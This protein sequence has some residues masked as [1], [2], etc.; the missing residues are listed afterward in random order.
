MNN[1][2]VQ[3]FWYDLPES[4]I[5]QYPLEERDA[6][7]LL[8]FRNGRIAHHNFRSLPELLPS[9]AS[10]FFNNTRV[11]PARLKFAKKSGA[12]IEIFLLH[13]VQPTRLVAQ[14]MLTKRSAQWECIIGNKKRWK[15]TELISTREGLVIEAR[16]VDPAQNVVEFVWTPPELTFSEMLSRLGETPLPPY[17]NREAATSDQE[18]Y[19]TVYSKEA[20]AVAAPTA[21]LHFT[22]RV[23][24]D[25]T[26]KGIKKDFLTLH[27]SAGTFQPIK[28]EN[29]FDHIM[30]SEQV[31]VNAANIS[32][33]LESKMTVAVG[34][35]AMR[36]LESLYWYGVKLLQQ[37]DAPFE[38]S[39]TDAWQL[40]QHVSIAAA[41]EAIA[42][43][44]HKKGIT[45]LQ[46][47]TS[48]YITPG[49]QFRICKGLITNFH[50]PGSTLMLLI[51][52]FIGE[53][54]KTVYQEA[55]ANNYRFLSYGDS[56]LLFGE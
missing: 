36:T 20:G 32:N 28:T 18:K 41:L 10:L 4:R 50:Q 45:S 26:T 7:N 46:G 48:I 11:I 25:L 8:V 38:I 16:L 54:W 19:Q 55:L 56:S 13:P 44:M 1:L 9:Q 37:P 24:N 12:I 3:D 15:E 14:A 17:L 51:A 29:A 5:A 33:I 30:H 22:N 31:I 49:Y 2:P 21:G 23:L 27:V 53:H 43:M 42:A 40:P 34:T 35:T 39:Q 52:A 47:T 6:S